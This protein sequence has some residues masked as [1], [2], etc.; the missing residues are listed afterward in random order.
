MNLSNALAN[1]EEISYS[2]LEHISEG[3]SLQEAQ[4]YL[5]KAQ[6]NL[7]NLYNQ[8]YE[9]QEGLRCTEQGVFDQEYL[10]LWSELHRPLDHIRRIS[11]EC[12]AE[13]ANIL[14]LDLAG[15]F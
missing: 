10:S 3:E 8:G 7:R 14:D 4:N 9:V 12:R 1:L 6:I 2:L 5:D 15:N 13:D 11:E